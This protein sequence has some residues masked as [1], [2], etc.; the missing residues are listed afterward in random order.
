MEILNSV[1][2][3]ELERLKNLKKHYEQEISEFPKGSLIKKEINGHEYYYLN[4][5]EE[6][7]GV[8]KYIGK[9]NKDEV[10]EF[11]R[12]IEERRKLRKLN[13]KVKQDIAK[14]EKMIHEKKK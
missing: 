10:K 2:K 14:L 13:I 5:R 12:K 9:L 3:E 7:K 6:G 11:K 4:Y 1:L 8:F